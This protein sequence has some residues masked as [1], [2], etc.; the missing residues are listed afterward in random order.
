MLRKNSPDLAKEKTGEFRCL[1]MDLKFHAGEYKIFPNTYFKQN[2]KDFEKRIHKDKFWYPPLVTTWRTDRIS[3]KKTEEIPNTKRPANLH[4][5]VTTHLI[6]RKDGNNLQF[7]FR[8][9]EGAMILKL[10]DV[11]TKQQHSSMIGGGLEES[12]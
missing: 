12:I 10:L 1:L 4:H 6:Q 7:D 8:T 2:R 11:I 9:N 3:G 5:V